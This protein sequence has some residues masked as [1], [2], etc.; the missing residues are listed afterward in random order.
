[1]FS[2][3]RGCIV[4]G[5]GRRKKRKERKER[6][7]HCAIWKGRE[8][9]SLWIVEEFMR[10]VVRFFEYVLRIFPLFLSHWIY[11]DVHG[12]SLWTNWGGN[13]RK[14]L[15]V[16]FLLE[17]QIGSWP[18]R[19]GFFQICFF[20]PPNFDHFKNIFLFFLKFN[21]TLEYR[22]CPRARIDR[23]IMRMIGETR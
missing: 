22:E 7:K 21:R 5:N 15:E 3:K 16:N 23:A 1:M 11:I 18:F 19:I 13:F 14:S 20:F 10:L 6:R 17:M 9:G 8:R 2:G 12:V 4:D